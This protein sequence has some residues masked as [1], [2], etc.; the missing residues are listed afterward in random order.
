MS[1]AL[2]SRSAD[3]TRL[4]EE[5]YDVRVVEGHLLLCNVPY[6]NAKQEVR[7]GT[8]VS[9]LEMQGDITAKPQQHVAHFGGEHPCHADGRKFTEIE[10]GSATQTLAPGVEVNHSFSSKPAGGYAD[11][12]DK[13]T[14]YANMFS[15]EAQCIDPTA[16]PRIYPQTRYTAAQSPFKYPDTASSRAG[17]VALHEPF[18]SQKVAVV[19]VGGTGS[20]IT[21]LLAKT[22]VAELHLF[23]GDDLLNHNAFRSPGAA[24][25]RELRTRP[26]KA[27]YFANK[28]SRMKNK[29]IA[30][31]Y[32]LT[33]ANLEELSAMTF[34]FLCID[35]PSAKRPIIRFLIERGM[36]FIDVGMGIE[37]SDGSLG[38]I[39]RSTLVMPDKQDHVERRISFQAG[40]EDDAYSQNI[41]VVEL[42]ALNATLAVLR[43]KRLLGFYRD[44]EQ[45]FHSCYTIDGNHIANDDHHES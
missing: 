12:Y 27:Q 31:P 25:L 8:L 18:R 33:D 4:Q 23:D 38:G 37:L 41:Q 36:A 34:V 3:L 28:Y 2:I 11:Y 29:V 43:W 5:G 10:H 40:A 14:T 19:G 24:S 7:L 21:D 20:Y 22:P 16:T 13:M 44:A 1:H 17:I 26:N 35:S 30:H 32:Y 39:L 6:V 45:E 42:N 15:A 9:N